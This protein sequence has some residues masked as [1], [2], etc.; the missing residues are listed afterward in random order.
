MDGG[1]SA[2]KSP[3]R[4]QLSG[5]ME[6]HPLKQYLALGAGRGRAQAVLGM[7]VVDQLLHGISWVMAYHLIGN[8]SC[9]F[10]SSFFPLSF[11]FSANSIS[12]VISPSGE[13]QEAM[14]KIGTISSFISSKELEE[15][16][17]GGKDV[18][19]DKNLR[20]S[21][22]SSRELGMGDKQGA[23]R[24]SKHML[25]RPRRASYTGSRL[26]EELVRMST[27]GQP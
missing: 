7:Q 12:R 6:I 24:S 13:N 2:D 10:P 19:V 4:S 11:V 20:E 26:R 27:S 16:V 9:F 15:E 8:S 23:S 22:K 14:R 5:T 18:K 21:W 17:S 25:R 3:G 1:D